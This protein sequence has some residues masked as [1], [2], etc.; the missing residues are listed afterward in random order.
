[1]DDKGQVY[2]GADDKEVPEED[3]A[4]LKEA[5]REAYAEEV[6]KLAG[7]DAIGEQSGERFY[8]RTL[9]INPGPDDGPPWI[10]EGSDLD[11]S[12]QKEEGSARSEGE[13]EA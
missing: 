4:R 3:A 7:R 9:R 6:A 11:Q 13:Q 8:C 2:F 12:F 10:P 1:M 5:Y